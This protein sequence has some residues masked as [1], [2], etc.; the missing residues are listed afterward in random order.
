V[1]LGYGLASLLRFVSP[2]H[3][4]L[5]FLSVIVL[6]VSFRWGGFALYC[7]YKASRLAV[8]IRVGHRVVTG[9]FRPKKLKKMAIKRPISDCI[10]CAVRHVAI[11][12]FVTNFVISS[13][14]KN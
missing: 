14:I 4:G 10:M 8:C 5:F 13:K 6:F 12:T 11:I 2:S 1:L 7:C 3:R 9:G